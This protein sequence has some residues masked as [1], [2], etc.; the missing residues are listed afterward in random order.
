VQTWQDA[1]RMSR[2]EQHLARAI[3]TSVLVS[4]VAQLR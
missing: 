3:A 4:P 1:D 2:P